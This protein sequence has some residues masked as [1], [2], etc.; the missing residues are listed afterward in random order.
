MGFG[1]TENDQPYHRDRA[2]TGVQGLDEILHGG[3]PDNRSYLIEGGPGTGKTTLA[4]QFLLEGA[5]QDESGLFI[6]LLQS[7]DEVNDTA[8]SHG[9]SLD[10]LHF[11]ELPEDVQQ[12]TD[13]EQTV[14]DPAEV[15]LDEVTTAIID[16]IRR[17]RP[18]RFVLDSLSELNAIVQND[19]QLRRQLVKISV[20]INR[21]RHCS[22]PTGPSSN[23]SR[24][25][26][27]SCTARSDC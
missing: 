23:I 9:W 7:R 10:N 19:Y 11:V 13:T 15:E 17:H 5:R 16:A 6:S 1:M 24:R 20:S 3:L 26:I 22:H 25:S 21:A 14:F 2:T 4:L 8:T 18:R 27:R 12:Y